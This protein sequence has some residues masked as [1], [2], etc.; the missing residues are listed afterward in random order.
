MFEARLTHGIVLKKIIEAIKDLVTDVN[1][2]IT[3]EG[4]FL[5][6]MDS[7]HVALVT[8][9]LKGS[10]F[11]EYRCDRPQ[12]LGVSIVNLAKLM[13][14]ASNDDAIVLRAE[15][16]A[17]VLT[18]IFE[19][20]TESKVSEFNLNL[21]TIDSEHLGIP[22]QDY[23]AVIKMSSNEFSRICREL[24]TITD[25]LNISADKESLKFAVSGD[26][27]AGSITLRNYESDK[28]E[29]R[30]LL[31]VNEPVRMAFA[32]R[33]LNMFNKAS[34]LSDTVT[35]FMSPDIP[36][37]VEYGFETGHLRYYLAPKIADE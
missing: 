19:G 33:Y 37:V 18:M 13:K 32:L 2:E 35:L 30:T 1:F 34:S 23:N 8:L 22:D 27:G 5:Q 12:T 11:A 16:E 10:E 14:L 4:I 26:I 21:I 7:S 9:N 15:D 36:I 17:N 6:A 3:A 25:T 28:P 24:T 20:T 31:E 29:D